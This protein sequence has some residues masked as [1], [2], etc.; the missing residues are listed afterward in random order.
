MFDSAPITSIFKFCFFGIY[1]TVQT[2][3][4]TDPSTSV[5]MSLLSSSLQSL[6]SG[7]SHWDWNA[8]KHAC[9]IN[10]LA[11]GC[12]GNPYVLLTTNYYYYFIISNPI[13]SN[14]IQSN[15]IQSNPYMTLFHFQIWWWDM[16][17][18]TTTHYY[19]YY[20]YYYYYL[21]PLYHHLCM[22]MSIINASLHLISTAKWKRTKPMGGCNG[23]KQIPEFALFLLFF[24]YYYRRLTTYLL[25]TT[26][27]Y[28]YYAIP[29][30]TYLAI[31]NCSVTPPPPSL[32]L[33]P[34]YTSNTHTHT[35]TKYL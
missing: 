3:R 11:K 32:S 28:Y 34:L 29:T 27:T 17:P 26:P 18:P 2:D 12:L 33:S 7:D 21:L 19:H 24:L 31:L 8:I 6:S 23:A 1:S 14:P 35:I 15:P 16:S 9:Y 30:N 10:P 25:L 20:Y 5:T 4:Q 22:I 13:Q